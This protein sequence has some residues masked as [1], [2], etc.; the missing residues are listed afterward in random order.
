[1]YKGLTSVLVGLVTRVLG[2]NGGARYPGFPGLK[3]FSSRPEIPFRT[4]RSPVYLI[5]LVERR[6]LRSQ[7]GVPP[8]EPCSTACGLLALSTRSLL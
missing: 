8:C 7:V 4:H 5:L 3:L 1:M 2:L 6:S